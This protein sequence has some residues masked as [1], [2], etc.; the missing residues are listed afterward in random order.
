MPNEGLE[1][2]IIKSK[3]KLRKGG[4]ENEETKDFYPFHPSDRC[5]HMPIVGSS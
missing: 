3:Q 5:A 2:M 4:K 1:I